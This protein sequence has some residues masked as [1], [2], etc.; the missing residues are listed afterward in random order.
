MVHE[1]ARPGRLHG[2][3]KHSL[4]VGLYSNMGNKVKEKTWLPATSAGMAARGFAA[5]SP[6]SE[7]TSGVWYGYR[8]LK[9][10]TPSR[11]SPNRHNA[12][13]RGPCGR[14]IPWAAPI[15]RGRVRR[16]ARRLRRAPVRPL[17]SA[18]AFRRTA[19]DLWVRLASSLTWRSDATTARRKLLLE[20]CAP[21]EAAERLI[22]RCAGP[23]CAAR[24][25]EHRGGRAAAAPR[26]R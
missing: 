14:R 4:I 21:I 18:A 13:V 23:R 26:A 15:A 2:A 9:N 22:T 8:T 19:P 6:M 3:N 5:S 11:P 24:R 17:A 12:S 16:G 10:P 25:R 20:G 1:R 7:V